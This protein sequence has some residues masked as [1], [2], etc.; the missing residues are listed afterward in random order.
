MRNCAKVSEI[1]R[2]M[3]SNQLI[4]IVYKK[5]FL[6]TNDLNPTFPSS[7]MFLLQDYED[8]FPKETPHGLPPIRGIEHPIDFVPDAYIPNWPA[9]R[10]NSKETKELQRQVTEL[11]EKGH[12]RKSVSP[13]AVPFLLVP[14]VSSSYFTPRW[15]AWWIAWFLCIF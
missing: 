10:S 9:Y 1:K 15:Y 13:C 5:E 7:I 12:V 8:D 4:I 6:S 11:M 2:T 3:F 14:K